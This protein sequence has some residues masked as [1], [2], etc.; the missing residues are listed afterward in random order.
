MG[1]MVI[2]KMARSQRLR[3]DFASVYTPQ[4]DAFSFLTNFFPVQGNQPVY[5]SLA[6][7][8]SLLHEGPRAT[9]Y[10]ISAAYQGGPFIRGCRSEL[11]TKVGRCN[12]HVKCVGMNAKPVPTAFLPTIKRSMI[13][14]TGAA[15]DPYEATVDR[16]ETDAR[17]RSRERRRR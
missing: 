16:S 15:R 9:I 17:D 6:I 14:F 13:I 2:I 7:R 12:G 10:G 8:F 5:S 4:N 1:G 3:K 11:C